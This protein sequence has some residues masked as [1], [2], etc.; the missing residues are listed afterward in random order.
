MY[1]DEN[2]E[3][4]LSRIFVQLETAAH[5]LAM[6]GGVAHKPDGLREI[7]STV[8]AVKLEIAGVED[9]ISQTEVLQRDYNTKG[10]WYRL[11]NS[12]IPRLPIGQW[13]RQLSV[14]KER[15]VELEKRLGQVQ[16]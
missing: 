6:L 7:E 2:I 11:W 16:V 1:F 5:A 9:Y 12:H 15:L 8:H 4:H 14:E 10:W 3:D 13:S